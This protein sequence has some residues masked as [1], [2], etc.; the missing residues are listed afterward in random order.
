M[1]IHILDSSFNLVDIIDDYNSMIWTTRYF[2]QGDFELHVPAIERNIQYLKRNYYLCRQEDVSEDEY[3]NVM[4]IQNVNIVTDVENGNMLTVTGKCLKSIVGRRIVWKQTNLSGYLESAIRQVLTENIINPEDS[5][6]KIAN[7]TMAPA[8]GI[9]N[10]IDLQLTGNNIA[11][12][13]EESCMKYGIGWDV[14]IKRGRFV[15]YLYL[16]ADRSTNQRTLP[17]VVFSPEFDNLLTS[18]YKDE[19]EY[20]KNAALVAGEGEGTAQKFATVGS[21]S[22]LDR[23]EEYIEASGMSTNDETI[24][25]AQY[26]KMLKEYGQSTLNLRSFSESFEGSVVPDG[27]YKLNQD[28][29]LGDI[30]QVINEYGITASTRVVEIIDSEDESGRTVIPTFNTWEV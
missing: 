23:Y 16:G 10:T 11:T 6:R 4:I 25:D 8:V 27:N 19:G 22:G 17:H 14:Y 2:S 7:F 13:L 24:T 1:D 9:T 18:D 12:W 28:Y 15:F 21:A 29:F 26:Q 20:Y 3:R 30:V 5:T